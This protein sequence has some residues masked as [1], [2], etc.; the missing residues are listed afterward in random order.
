M[1]QILAP[2]LAD[3]RENKRS[4]SSKEPENTESTPCGL[5]ASQR[6]ARAVV[7]HVLRPIVPCP[8]QKCSVSTICKAARLQMQ[9][10]QTG[11]S[12]RCGYRSST[13][14]TS[15]GDL[16]RSST[17]VLWPYG[18]LANIMGRNG[19]SVCALSSLH[20]R[21]FCPMMN[22]GPALDRAAKAAQA[23]QKVPQRWKRA[24]AVGLP[25]ENHG[26]S[27]QAD[28]RPRNPVLRSRAARSLEAR[29]CTAREPRPSRRCTWSKV[30]FKCSRLGVSSL[31]QSALEV[32]RC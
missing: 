11:S 6:M 25:T 5:V 12:H 16:F 23:A 4:A 3:L 26:A 24:P 21:G 30:S 9:R 1:A 13:T 28:Q 19:S 17:A 31:L 2:V 27:R 29:F 18:V 8:S 32:A 22:K 10:H 15:E 14:Y 20:K 7:I